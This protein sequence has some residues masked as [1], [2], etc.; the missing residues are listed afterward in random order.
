MHETTLHT[1][2]S[3][4]HCSS[5][6]FWVGLD[7]CAFSGSG[8]GGCCV[9]SRGFC[10]FYRCC[11][12][13]FAV[14]SFW[15]WQR[16][17]EERK[18]GS[19]TCVRASMSRRRA[20]GPSTQG[21]WWLSCHHMSRREREGAGTPLTL[22]RTLFWWEFT[23]QLRAQRSSEMAKEGTLSVRLLAGRTIYCAVL[24][25]TRKAGV[26][27]KEGHWQR[28]RTGVWRVRGFFAPLCLRVFCGGSCL[29][30]GVM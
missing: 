24:R 10:C 11:S 23:S 15:L 4:I 9:D 16:K 18:E 6:L 27:K 29:V 3:A 8:F 26:K 30:T 13:G 21:C 7:R 28:P 1:L 14:V 19:W 12:L 20:Q 25:R 2:R 5:P 22:H 17:K